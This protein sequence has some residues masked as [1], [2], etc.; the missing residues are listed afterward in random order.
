[1]GTA[2]IVSIDNPVSHES[3]IVPS[4]VKSAGRVLQ[5]LEFF[6]EIQRGACVSEISRFLRYP[7]SSTSVLLRSLVSMG[8]LLHDRHKRT[9]YPTRRVSLL[10]NW[11]DRSL[12]QQGTLLEMAEDL[13]R[14]SQQTVVMATANGLYAQYIYI[15]RARAGA[16]EPETLSIGMLRPIAQTAVGRAL[17]SAYDDNHLGKILRRINAERRANDELIDIPAFLTDIHHGRRRG[18]FVGAGAGKL[19]AGIATTLD[20]N[21][22]QLVIALE[23]AP[24]QISGQEEELSFLLRNHATGYH[25]KTMLMSA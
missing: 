6:D 18:Y 14:G 8:Y 3:E 13:A 22:Q 17:L 25:T 2:E 20:R 12:V 4:V 10:G 24:D 16:E 19:K 11:V 7:Q 23:G 9:Y 1:M 5:I 15:H 21:W